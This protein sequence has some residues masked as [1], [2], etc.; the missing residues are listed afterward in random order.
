VSG[1]LVV[2]VTLL[3]ACA[4]DPVLIAWTDRSLAAERIL[5]AGQYATA[6]AEFQA[7]EASARSDFD[8]VQAKTRRAEVH[9]R[10]GRLKQ[11]EALLREVVGESHKF[12]HETQAQ[13]RWLH[14]RAVLDLGQDARGERLLNELMNR[15]P[16]M[17]FGHRAFLYLATTYRQRDTDLLIEWCR[18]GYRRHTDTDLADNFAYEAARAHYL[19]NTEVDD[20]AATKLYGIVLERWGF[21]SSPLWDDALWE[22]SMIHHRRGRF[23]AELDLMKRL[24]S[25]RDTTWLGSYQIKNYRFA[26]FRIG[27]LYYF[28]LADAEKAARQF[29]DFEKVWPHSRLVDDTLWWRGHALLKAGKRKAAEGV[30]ARI[31]RDYPESKYVRRMD[32]G[33]VPTLKDGLTGP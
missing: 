17:I 11:Y 21:E 33:R 27:K 8:R 32:V 12:D 1:R 2:I 14:A 23:H 24:L 3:S 4:S 25:T 5:S 20:A 31:R 19:R 7:L 9:R 16:Q 18:R 6:L 13:L 28:E 15:R 22:L 26:H 29:A 30:F 10:A